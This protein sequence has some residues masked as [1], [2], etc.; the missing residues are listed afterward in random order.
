[1]KDIS[2]EVAKECAIH[3]HEGKMIV[4]GC[5]LMRLLFTF[6]PLA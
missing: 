3:R 6:H 2:L 1:M 4:N 5:V